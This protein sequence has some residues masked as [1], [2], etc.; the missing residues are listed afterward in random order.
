VDRSTIMPTIVREQVFPA[1]GSTSPRR[2]PRAQK[3]PAVEV[4]RLGEGAEVE[5]EVADLPGLGGLGQPLL[6]ELEIHGSPGP[7]STR[8]LSPLEMRYE[9]SPRRP[10]APGSCGSR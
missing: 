3:S 4:G 1:P 9:D 5:I 8:S 2:G 7:S 10:P 6:E